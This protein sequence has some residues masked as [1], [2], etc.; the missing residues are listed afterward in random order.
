M[1]K[2]IWTE[3]AV[4]HL[5][6]IHDYIAHDSYVYASQFIKVLIKQTKILETFPNSGRIVPEF[7][8]KF[9]REIIYNNYR[10]VYRL[11]DISKPEIIAV[12]HGSQLIENT[13]VETI[14]S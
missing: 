5:Q 12:M 3:K 1:G 7:S 10:I 14:N 11:K 13:I 2:V 8:D 9:L 4:V 6:S